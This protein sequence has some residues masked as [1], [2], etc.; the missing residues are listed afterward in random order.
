M[1]HYDAQSADIVII[2][3]GMGGA[4]SAWAL[5][6]TDARIVILEKGFQLPEQPENRDPKAIFQ[7]GFFRPHELWYDEK[8]RGFNPGN[9]YYHGGNTKLYG[10]VLARYRAED[11]DGLAHYD[12]DTPAWPFRYD[13]IA[14]WYDA[15]EQLYQVRGALGEDPTEPPHG[16]SYPHPA[17]PDEPPIGDVRARLAGAGLHPF[18]LP[19][20]LDLEQ[21]LKKA[22]TPWDTFPDA[23]TGKMDAENCALL[24]ALKYPNVS[25]RSGAEVVR[26]IVAPDGRKIAA[27]EYM[28]DGHTHRINAGTVILAAGAVRSASI[29]LRSDT[30]GLANRSDTV[31]RHF[32]NHNLTALIGVSPRYRNDSVYQKSFGLNDFYLSDGYEGRPLGSIQLFGRVSGPI[33]KANVPSVPEFILDFI[34]RHSIDFFAM[35]EDLPNPNSRVRLDGS[36][37]VLDW[38]RSNM[39]AHNLLVRRFK[40]VL[41]DIGFPFVFSRLLDRRLPSHQCGTIRIGDNPSKA[42]LDPYGRAFDHPNLFVADAS[43][44]V[45]SAAVNPSLTVAALALRTASEIKKSVLGI[46]D[47]VR[48]S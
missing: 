47:D 13:E 39:T 18:S 46:Q 34:S 28:Q 2:G 38:R 22:P 9:Y 20:G 6:P 17:I 5:A 41:K 35:S 19:L 25:I 1:E 32:M 4:T 15:A 14:P 44:L 8:G 16:T 30:D 3:S 10:C 29:L 7:R 23:R 33:L 36:K 48:N 45:T 21:W 37:I 27:V 11:F 24:P 43:T 31:G 40:R 26:L 42:P 12:G